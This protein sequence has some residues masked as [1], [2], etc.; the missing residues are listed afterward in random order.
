LGFDPTRTMVTLTI[1]RNWARDDLVTNRGTETVASSP[2][3]TCDCS[4]R[5]IRYRKVN[6]WSSVRRKSLVHDWLVSGQGKSSGGECPCE[7]GSGYCR[8]AVDKN[9]AGPVVAACL[10]ARD[11]CPKPAF[12]KTFLATQASGNYAVG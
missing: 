8:S 1:L 4:A 7:R 12:C 5:V 10:Q 6:S 11:E 9:P 2:P 3:L